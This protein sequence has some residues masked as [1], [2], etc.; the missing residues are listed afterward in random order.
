M[1]LLKIAE[2]VGEFQAVDGQYR[3]VDEITKDDL[4]RLVDR[5]LFEDDVEFDPYDEKSLKNQA[6]Q[7][8]YKSVLQKLQDLRNRRREFVDESARLFLEDY[9]R[10]REPP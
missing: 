10:Y 8:I 9:Q 2:N 5:T 6:H 3:T 7:V 4:L 1:K